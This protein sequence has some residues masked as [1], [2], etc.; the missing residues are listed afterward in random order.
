LALI[1]QLAL[2]T[3]PEY[4]VGV[5][6]TATAIDERCPGILAE[7]GRTAVMASQTDLAVQWAQRATVMDPW[8]ARGWLVL[9]NARLASGD[10]EGAESAIAQAE[11]VDSAFSDPALANAIAVFRQEMAFTN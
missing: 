11:A 1:E 6:A 7:A 4:A 3:P 5:A 9:A 2:S 10:K 8:L